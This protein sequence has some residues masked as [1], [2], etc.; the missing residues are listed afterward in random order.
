MVVGYCCGLEAPTS[1]PPTLSL[2]HPVPGPAQDSCFSQRRPL[3]LSLLLNLSWCKCKVK[4]LQAIIVFLVLYL[5]RQVSKELI[6]T[7]NDS[8]PRPNS[9]LNRTPLG[10]LCTALCDCWSWLVVIQPG[11]EPGSVVTPLALEMEFLRPLRHPGGA[12]CMN[13]NPLVSQLF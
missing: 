3:F 7:Y 5:T 9:P 10:Q 11:F 8:R 13:Y 4:C 12:R 6:L 2:S 1:P